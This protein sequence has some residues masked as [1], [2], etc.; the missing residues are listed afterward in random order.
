M[1]TETIT[2]LQFD[3]LSDE[4]KERAREWWRQCDAADGYHWWDEAKSS[5]DEFCERFNVKVEDY[6]VGAFSPS[7]VRLNVDRYD[8]EYGTHYDDNNVPG[9]SGI[10]LW[11]YL[12]NQCDVDRLL[13]QC[14]PF[15]GV[16][17]DESMLEPLRAFIERP[18]DRTY[19]MLIN[20]C[21]DSWLEY[22]VADMENQPD[23]NEVD[24]AIESNGYEFTESGGFH[25]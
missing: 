12:R 6:C 14:C 10:R 16:C 17:F 24:D 7:H 5:L 20:D 21:V 22:V 11:K 1:R 2:I 8:T 19:A 9:L 4:A 25:A 23:D 15:T 18:D 13:A 3:E